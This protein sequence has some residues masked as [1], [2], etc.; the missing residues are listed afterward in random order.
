[1]LRDSRCSVKEIGF[2]L[3]FKTASHFIAAFR[4]EFATTPQEFRKH[5]GSTDLML[6]FS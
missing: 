5:G 3:G 1:L 4:R 6:Q 2:Q